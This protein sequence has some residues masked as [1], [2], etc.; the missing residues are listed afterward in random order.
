[1]SSHC[2]SMAP[3]NTLS[4]NHTHLS[5]KH[6]LLRMYTITWLW[7]K[8]STT[9]TIR[10]QA[11]QAQGQLVTRFY[12]TVSIK[13]LLLVFTCS[14]LPISLCNSSHCSTSK[15]LLLLQSHSSTFLFV[16]LRSHARHWYVV[17]TSGMAAC[18]VIKHSPYLKWEADFVLWWTRLE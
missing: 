2:Y 15:R 18:R 1:M 6:L 13:L 10:L 3:S 14:P 17:M 4:L 12:H 9:T 16:F 8:I 11:T 5:W 7:L